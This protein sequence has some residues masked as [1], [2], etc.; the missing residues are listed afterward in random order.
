[1]KNAVVFGATG[2]LGCYSAI[3]LKE[4]GYNVYAVGRRNSDNGF[5]ET[6]GITFIGGVDC[7]TAHCGRRRP[8]FA[9]GVNTSPIVPYR[10]LPQTLRG[11]A[12]DCRS[13]V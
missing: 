8:H 3:A 4:D 12:A 9:F 2:Q 13:F 7:Q 1:M 6:K 11:M 10:Y 5:F